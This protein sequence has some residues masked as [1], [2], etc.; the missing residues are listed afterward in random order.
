[1][2]HST[3]W[4]MALCLLALASGCATTAN[5]DPYENLN[6]P[7]MEF[8]D[9]VDGISLKPIAKGYFNV[10]PGRG[11]K[12]VHNFF[13][14]LGYPNVAINQFLQGK[15]KLG[16]S[17]TLR[18]LINSTVGIVGLFDVATRLGLDAH[19]EDF[20]QTFAVWGV[21]S[22]PYF[23]APFWGPVTVRDAVGDLFNALTF[24][25]YYVNDVAL[26]NSLTAGW[27]VDRRA[28][29]L[30]GE[31]LISGDRYLFIRDAYL[32]HREFLIHDGEVD[33]P[34]FEEDE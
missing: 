29:V 15:V 25:T 12:I 13:S 11:R 32:Q 10:I 30:E 6:R 5:V 26:R 34:F 8:N 19:D 20:G 3:R 23:M 7:V 24:P 9:G 1:M 27:A 33:D 4:V 18:F 28:A 2:R 31:T 14:N 16:V 17:D 22:G 21:A